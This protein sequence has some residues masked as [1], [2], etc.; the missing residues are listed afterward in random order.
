MKKAVGDSKER[1]MELLLDL[2]MVVCIE[3]VLISTTFSPFG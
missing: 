2:A 3:Y 1:D